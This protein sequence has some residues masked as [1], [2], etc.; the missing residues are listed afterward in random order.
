[1]NRLTKTL[2]LLG[3]GLMIPCYLFVAG[4]TLLAPWP[5]YDRN[6]AALCILTAL[7]LAALLLLLRA[8]DR[9]EAFLNRHDKRIV[10]I[11]AVFYF[12]VSVFSLT[13]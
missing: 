12:A 1:M 6:R 9:H 7:F 8:V 3:M 2:L 4:N 5:L 11:A 13:F 10:L